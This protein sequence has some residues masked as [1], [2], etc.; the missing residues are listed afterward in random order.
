MKVPVFLFFVASL[1]MAGLPA[2]SRDD[3]VNSPAHPAVLV[4]LFTSEGCSDCPPADAFLQKLD[5]Q[6]IST[7]QLIVLSEHVE[8]WNHDGWTDPYSSHTLTERQDAYGQHFHLASVYTPQMIVDGTEQFVGNNGKQA[9]KVLLTAA[10]AMKVPVQ[11]KG[12]ALD[13]SVIHAHIDAAP[14]PDHA[15]KSD[16]MFAV[17]LNHAESQVSNGENAGRHLVHV[18]VVRSIS[19]VGTIDSQGAFSQDIAI[20]LDKAVEASDLRVVAFIQE[21]GPSR[22]LGATLQKLAK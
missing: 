6:P 5:Q 22:V 15:K 4:E 21:P 3:K 19:K 11:I 9:E 7:E 2:R 20:K 1:T 17:A 8:Y 14:L 12:A 10:T 16:V 13:G 18:A